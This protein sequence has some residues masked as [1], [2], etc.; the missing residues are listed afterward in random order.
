MLVRSQAASLNRDLDG[1]RADAVAIL[2]AAVAAVEPFALVRGALPA[3]ASTLSTSPRVHVV[4]AGKAAWPMAQAA[5]AFLGTRLAGGVVSG[6]AGTGSLPRELEWVHGAHPLPDWRSVHAA[7]RALDRAAEA[8]RNDEM[9]LVLLSGGGSSM[10]AHPAP[11]LTLDDKRATIEQLLRAG[12]TVTDLNTV[13][14]HLSA[15]KGGRLSATHAT[16]CLTLA[17]SDVHIPQDDPATIASGPT[18]PDP[19]T[20]AEALHIVVESGIE[21]PLRVRAHLERGVAGHLQDTPKAED[22]RLRQSAFAVIA[23]RRTAMSGAVREAERRGYAVSVVDDPIHGEASHAGRSFAEHALANEGTSQPKCVIAAG[24]TTVAVKGT[25]RGGRNQEFA[26]GAAQPLAQPNFGVVASLGTDGIDGPTDAA[27]AIVT[28]S[29]V[30][31]ATAWGVDLHEV[32]SR[33]DAYTV[34]DKLDA[35][36]KWGPTFTNVGDV[37]VLLTAP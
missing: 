34:L 20:Y 15:I 22:P 29:T 10:L 24:E 23:N 11:G 25:G 17:I 2:R 1:L 32:L 21:I 16:R 36:I 27:G 3:H 6:P 37:H 33:N 7:R 18:V 12:V 35:L 4:A 26:L 30:S 9:L 28:S 8:S 5:V 14:K 31:Q 13:R 19:T